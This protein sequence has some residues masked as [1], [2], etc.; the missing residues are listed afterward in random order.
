L[1][2]ITCLETF[3]QYCKKIQVPALTASHISKRKSFSHW[4]RKRFNTVSCR[5][6]LFSDEKIFNQDGIFN[7]Q[8]E[9]VYA[10]SRQAA[11][12]KI[13]LSPIHRF[14]FKVM[15]WLG[16]SYNGPT[17]IVV[18]RRENHL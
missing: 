3:D 4:I 1:S 12:E 17:K 13:G 7:R 10:A 8:N 18:L 14:P 5:K 6:I 15:V 2:I 16:L 11:Y 9:R